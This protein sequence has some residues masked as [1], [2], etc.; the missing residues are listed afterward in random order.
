MSLRRGIGILV[1][2]LVLSG[3]LPG[4]DQQ[5]L[6]QVR[7]SELKTLIGGK[8]VT[9]QLAEGGKLEG[10]IGTVNPASLAFNVTKSSNLKDYPKG[11]IRI[12]RETVSRIEVRG[13]KENKAKRIAA[14]AG[15]FVGTMMGSMVAI[16]GTEAGEPGDKYYGSYAASIAI[17][18]GVAILVNRALRP[19]DITLIEILP[20]STGA[21]MPPHTNKIES[22]TATAW[23]EAPVPSLLEL[24]EPGSARLRRQARRDLM[25]QGLPLD[26]GSPP[27]QGV[28]AGMGRPG[29]SVERLE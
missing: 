3:N 27:V 25:R 4:S 23:G 22:S 19:K 14:T 7:W 10:R 28:Q 15:T 11:R 17:S 2:F 8:K 16:A 26:L 24:D 1:V 6:L 29:D 21:R 9:L 12:P 13:L 5:E 18:T 20:D